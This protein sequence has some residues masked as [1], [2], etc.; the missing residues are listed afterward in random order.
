[1]KKLVWHYSGQ[2]FG[3]TAEATKPIPKELKIALF[4]IAARI[5]NL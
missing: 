5:E 1:M 2:A 3:L 4:N